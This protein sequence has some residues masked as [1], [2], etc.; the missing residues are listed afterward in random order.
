MY[1]HLLP[2]EPWLTMY[3][4]TSQNTVDHGQSQKS[5]QNI[6]DYDLSH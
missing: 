4:K 2:R 1:K 3:N 6:V 5:W